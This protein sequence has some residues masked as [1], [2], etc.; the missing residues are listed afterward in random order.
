MELAKTTKI[1]GVF[2][3]GALLMFID[4]QRTSQNISSL[5]KIK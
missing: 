1:G 2:D 3:I 5:K 4:K